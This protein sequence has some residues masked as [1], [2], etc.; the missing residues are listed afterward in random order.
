MYLYMGI[1]FMQVLYINK[2]YRNEYKT[3]LTLA[4]LRKIRD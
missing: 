2:K 4:D 1:R 3:S